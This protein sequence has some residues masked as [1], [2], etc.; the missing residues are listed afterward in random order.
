MLYLE[1]LLVAG[2]IVLNG[3]LAMSELA[4]VSSKPGR[5]KAMKDRGVPGAGTALALAEDPGRF[6]STVQVGITLV[7][8]L[9]GAFSGASLGGR[10]SG[11][12]TELGLARSYADPIGFTLVITAITYFSLVIGEL[13][14]K[15]IALRD[16]EIIACRVAVA[17]RILSKFAAPFVWVLDRS[18]RILIRLMGRSESSEATVTDEEIH[19]LIAEAESA[20]VIES[21]ER[22]M[23]AG[24]MRL[25]D[26]PVR[27]VMTP[28]TD[29]DLVGAG[30][31]QASL[32]RKIKA[33][34]H[35][36]LPVH[37]EDPE[38]VIGIVLIKDITD[39]LLERKKLDISQLVQKVPVIPESMPA[40]EAMELFRGSAIHM[41]FVQDEYGRTLGIVSAAD[42][43][44]AIAGTFE[45]G[46]EGREGAVQRD[47]GS[48]LLP[49][50]M[51][52]DEMAELIG[53]SLPSRRRYETVAGLLLDALKHLPALGQSVRV[54]QW[55]FEVIDLDGRRVDKVLVSRVAEVH[56]RAS[57]RG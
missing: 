24:V 54:G 13:V 34:P 32:R 5:L 8:I 7:G 17:M 46:G 50:S 6:L 1:I 22:N 4:V 30:D 44:K 31:D 33:S 51:A 10:L 25:G 55:R 40:L 36:R 27:A 3:V 57:S 47:D 53:F 49:G 20:G 56:R 29:V 15:Q 45:T 9:A 19:T 52:V 42:L 39:A 35:S 26:R 23:I 48:W 16:S 11:W 38:E 37:G 18:G 14:P 28:L 2:L 12:L 41:A 43:L 21:G